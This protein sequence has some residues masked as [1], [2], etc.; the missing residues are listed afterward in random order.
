M[1]ARQR[2]RAARAAR[3]RRRARRRRALDAESFAAIVAAARPSD[4]AR[5]GRARSPPRPPA[6]SCS[7][8]G[9]SRRRAPATPSSWRDTPCST[10]SGAAS[11]T[12]RSP[13][14]GR[15]VGLPE[16]Q[17]GNSEVGH[18]NLGA[19]AVV[20]QDLTRIDDAV[21]T[22]SLAAN[23][24]LGEAACARRGARPP[25]RPG[26]RRRRALRLDAPRGADRAGGARA[27]VEDLVIHA[28]TDGRD[29]LPTSGAGYLRG[30]R[31]LVRAAR[32]P[33]A[34]AS[35]VRALLRDGPRLALGPHRARLRPARPRPRRRMPRR[36]APRPS[37]RP[38]SA[39][40]PTSSS[41]RR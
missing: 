13:R 11:R 17:M 19:G 12:R 39:A 15:S 37:A 34:S 9:A 18:L 1:N 22:A 5:R 41:S 4:A 25:D 36:P 2:G 23:E 6:S 40:R 35:V 7:T 8:A 31:G 38:T 14:R 33:D 29:T 28:F 20:P 30:R 21:E 32:A 27:G 26:V 24:V 3:R 16:G 10:G